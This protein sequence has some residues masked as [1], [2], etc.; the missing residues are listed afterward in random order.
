MAMDENI[1]TFNFTN[2][3]TIVAMALIGF[4]GLGFLQKWWANR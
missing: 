2:A 3:L 1:I 4:T